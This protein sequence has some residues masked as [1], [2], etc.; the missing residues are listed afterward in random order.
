VAFGSFVLLDLLL[1]EYSVGP[2][3]SRGGLA[4]MTFAM[5]AAVLTSM[6]L[7]SMAAAALGRYPINS[8]RNE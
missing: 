1:L 7:T 6:V 4:A 3:V 8:F 5:G 2:P